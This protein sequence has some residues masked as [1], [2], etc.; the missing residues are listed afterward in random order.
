MIIV[1][2]LN[3]SRAQRILWLLEEL[4]LAYEIK[5]YER[6]PDMRAPDE[7]K[8]IHPLG[9]SPVIEDRGRVIAE[10]GAIIEYLTAT[11]GNGRLVPPVG[12]EEWVRYIYWLH[13]AEGTALP[14]FQ[15]WFTFNLVPTQSPAIIRPIAS[16]IS[17]SVCKNLLD[18]QI[19]TNFAL[20]EKELARDGWFAGVQ[21]TAADIIMSYPVYAGSTRFGFDES[22][23]AT[24]AFFDAI[25]ARPAFRR[26]M[27]KA[28]EVTVNA[29][30]T[31]K[32]GF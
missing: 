2:F 21:F 6:G 14:L 19:R 10:S 15:T 4:E 12:T 17:R 9:K 16:M 8:R 13:Y 3:N 11:Y 1:H 7:L 30:P 23:I 27:E 24:K 25:R 26:A 20:W 29:N 31:D 5:P 32:L 18:P 28:G 22:M